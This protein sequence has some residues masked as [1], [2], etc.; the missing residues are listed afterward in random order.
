MFDLT[1][2][3]SQCVAQV[4]FYN[5]VILIIIGIFVTDGLMA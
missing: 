3:N 5:I 4:K 2:T 1:D